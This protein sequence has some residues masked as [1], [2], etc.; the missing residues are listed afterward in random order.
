MRATKGRKAEVC[1]SRTVYIV[2]L[3]ACYLETVNFQFSLDSVITSSCHIGNLGS[4]MTAAKS[5]ISCNLPY[6]VQTQ[7]KSL[8]KL[9]NSLRLPIF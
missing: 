6:A 5:S 2:N 1:K 7:R 8:C 9:F 4:V 3:L